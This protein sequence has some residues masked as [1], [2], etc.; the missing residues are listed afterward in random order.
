V[1]AFAYDAGYL[2][3]IEVG[4]LDVMPALDARSWYRYP[5]IVTRY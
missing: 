5:A 2:A 4:N 3:A 1:V